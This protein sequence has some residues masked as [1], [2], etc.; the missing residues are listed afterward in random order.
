MAYDDARAGALYRLD[1]GQGTGAGDASRSA[2]GSANSDCGTMYCIDTP[3]AGDANDYGSHPANSAAARSQF[4]SRPP[5][6]HVRGR[7]RACGWQ[8]VRWCG[9]PVAPEGRPHR[10]GRYAAGDLVRSP[11]RVRRADH[12]DRGRCPPGGPG[13][14]T[15]LRTPAGDAYAC[16]RP[17]SRLT[18]AG[19]PGVGCIPLTMGRRRRRRARVAGEAGTSNG[20]GS[21]GERATAPPDNGS[22]RLR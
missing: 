3:T 19:G 6:R 5:G 16:R 2:T 10:R 20:A 12:H 13:R 15:D 22:A 17:G 9:A 8:P 1:P 18:T 4:P 11:A 14:W 7:R 21:A